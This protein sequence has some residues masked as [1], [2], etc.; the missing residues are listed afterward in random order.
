EATVSEATVS[1]ATVSEATVSEATVSEATVSES[2]ATVSKDGEPIEE[3]IVEGQQVEGLARDIEVF[4]SANIIGLE[5]LAREQGPDVFEV[6]RDL[7]GVGIQGGPRTSGKSF[8]IRGFSSNEDVLIRIDGVTQNFEKYRYGAGVD[9]EPELLKEIAVYRGG[10]ATTQGSGYLGGVIEME[11]KDARD[12]LQP[13]QRWGS[14]GKI[15]YR[16]VNDGKVF[17]TTSYAAP[18]E[19]VDVLFNTTK[20]FTNDYELPDGSRFENSE[21]SQLSFLGKAEF[22]TDTLSFTGTQRHGEDSGM[23]PFDVTGGATGVGGTVLR[24]STE[25]ATSLRLLWDPFTP[26]ARWDTSVGFINKQV[27]DMDST[28][29]GVDPLTGEPLGTD[30]FDYQIWTIGS[31]N[32]SVFSLG[33]TDNRLKVG[34]QYNRERRLAIR[35]N[36][37]GRFLNNRQPTGT[38]K[39]YGVFAEHELS[40][41]NLTL[42]GGLRRDWYEII[43]GPDSQL[44]LDARGLDE[45]IKFARTTPAFAAN[46]NYKSVDLFYS[47]RQAFRAPLIDEY[48]SQGTFSRCQDFS[49]FLDIPERPEEQ[50]PTLPD[51]G[52]IPADPLLIPAWVVAAV[53]RSDE[54]QALR[55]ANEAAVAAWEIAVEEWRVDPLSRERAFCGAFYEPESSNNHEVGFNIDIADL[56]EMRKTLALKLTYFH[57]RVENVLESIFENASTGEVSQPGIEVRKGFELELSYSGDRFFSDFNL[58][59]ISGYIDYNFFVD[60]TDPL[61]ASLGIDQ[62]VDLFNVDANNFTFTVGA[63]LPWDIEIAHRLRAYDSRTITT[64]SNQLCPSALFVN[65]VCNEFGEQSGY[66]TSN[67]FASWRPKRN[68]DVRLTV[69]N[70]LNKTY[71]LAGFGGSI[72]AIAPGRDVRLSIRLG[73]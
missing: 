53:A 72:G 17:S 71:Q 18:L 37:E 73:Y 63:R 27:L 56:F 14:E 20:R 35:D 1:E 59:T 49:S 12:F 58:S 10:A 62:P 15:G 28:I 36:T 41:R 13:G 19:F 30:Q 45:S 66:M 7:P 42:R 48:F 5:D 11:T 61:I 2:D 32:E 46:F 67:F 70:A 47:W 60:N 23:E 55:T 34:A 9:I 25:D 69:D 22:F 4:D 38:K 57:V 44:L 31:E 6:L 50:E 24:E 3:I 26:W 65:P 8:T 51:P 54:E 43:A 40:W 64:G 52:P 33:P 16:T 29:A 21:E 39:Y 68:I